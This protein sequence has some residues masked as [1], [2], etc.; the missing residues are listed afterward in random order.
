MPQPGPPPEPPPPQLRRATG[1][2]AA[3]VSACVRVAYT[4]YI[5]RIGQTPGPLCDDY[6]VLLKN[7]QVWVLE[8]TGEIIGLLVLIDKE[9]HL[10]LDNVAVRPEQQG[11]GFGKR[12]LQ[13]AE[14]EAFRRGYTEL[15]LY[16]HE[17]MLE[18]RALYERLGYETFA[19]RKERGLKRVYMRKQLGAER[20]TTYANRQG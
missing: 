17:K 14:S 19:R 13:F 7:H 3:A 2:D 8:S 6:T 11:K 9:T 20:G 16:T 18:N 5:K 10:L 4:P 12:L 15:Q 1:A